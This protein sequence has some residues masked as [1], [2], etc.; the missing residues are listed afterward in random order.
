MNRYHILIALIFLLSFSCQKAQD[1]FLI[2]KQNI[3]LLTDSSKVQTLE[4]IYINDSIVKRI[5]GDEFTGIINDIEIFDK[6]TKSVLLILTPEHGLDSTSTIST[7]TIKDVRFKTAKGLSTASTFGD[8]RRDYKIS[9][10]QNTLKNVVIF[11]N[12]LNAFFTIDK[13]QLPE[14]LRY[15]LSANIEAIQIPDTAK[16][17]YFMIGWN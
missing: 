17:K 15:D 4:S 6:T 3:G 7:I 12:E 13:K 8:I 2:G 14:K 1:P 5:G 10:I 9:S 11:V 16:I